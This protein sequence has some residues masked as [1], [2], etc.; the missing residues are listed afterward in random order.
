MR[1]VAIANQMSCIDSRLQKVGSKLDNPEN[2]TSACNRC[3]EERRPCVISRAG[4]KPTVPPLPYE[5]RT[6]GKDYASSD[7]QADPFPHTAKLLIGA[8]SANLQCPL[9]CANRHDAIVNKLEYIKCRSPSWKTNQRGLGLGGGQYITANVSVTQTRD[10]G[11]NLR[12][13][14]I[15]DYRSKKDLRILN[16][17]WGLELSLCTGIARR[18]KLRS[19][20]Y[21]EVLGY[22]AMGL[23]GE[24]DNIASLVSPLAGMTD[25]ELERMLR[26]ELKDQAQGAILSKPMKPF[27][28]LL[29]LL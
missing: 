27:L 11:R 4:I 29:S 6:R 23:P 10:D 3:V 26:E 1:S 20:L 18:V 24:W 21:G 14:L 2:P 12:R 7:I 13:H 5:L 9:T 19:L 25:D 8:T 16:C 22:L 28:S 17:P 15:D